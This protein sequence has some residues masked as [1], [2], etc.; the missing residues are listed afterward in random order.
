MGIDL[1]S[2]QFLCCA[3]SMGV[4]F[5]DAI[6]VGRQSIS[7]KPDIAATVL[8]TLGV[9]HDQAVAAFKGRFAEPLFSILGAKQISSI[10]AADY[11]KA[12]YVHDFNHPIPSELM[13]R[14]S[15]VHDG[16]TIEHV[17]NIP[18]AFKNCMNMVRVGGHFIQINVANN[19]M[20]HGFWQFCPELIYRVFSPENGFKIVAVLMHEFH[21]PA[22]NGSSAGTWYKVEDPARL[23]RRAELINSR[24]TYICTIAQRIEDIEP[25]AK[26]PQQSDYVLT[27]EMAKSGHSA[28]NR[29]PKQHES[30]LRAMIPMSLRLIVRRC[31][32]ALKTPFEQQPH[33]RRVSEHDLICG[34][35]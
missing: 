23:Q 10:D 15:A 12:T 14:F 9:P 18:Q 8:S 34:H 25:F 20:G 27:W 21:S 35:L 2:V 24:P 28:D 19:Y 29:W 5:S 33:Y 32:R 17:F 30:R 26:F 6:M 4:D 3:K 13:R 16:G 7:V 1:P 11:E 22:P 31:R